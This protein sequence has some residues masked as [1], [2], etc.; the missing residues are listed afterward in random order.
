MGS[1]ILIDCTAQQPGI[2]ELFGVHPAGLA[3]HPGEHY[4]AGELE[5]HRSGS[6]RPLSDTSQDSRGFPLVFW[7]PALETYVRSWECNAPVTG[8][9]RG[10]FGPSNNA[11]SSIGVLCQKRGWGVRLTAAWEYQYIDPY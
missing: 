4:G 11:A 1:A 5:E 3:G 6:V 7:V 9:Q 2:I 10:P 8:H